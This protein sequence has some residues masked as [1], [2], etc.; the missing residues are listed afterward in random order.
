MAYSALIR[1]GVIAS[2]SQFHCAAGGERKLLNSDHPMESAAEGLGS[3]R[4]DHPM[5]V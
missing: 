3:P 4:G 2:F 1:N 5:S